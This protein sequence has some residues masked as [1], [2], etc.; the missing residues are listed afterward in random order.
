[1]DALYFASLEPQV[2][3]RWRFRGRTPAPNEFRD[4][5]FDPGVL[6][7]FMVVQADT[8]DPIGL[9]SSYQAS[10]VAKHCFVAF[11]RLRTND[12]GPTG[13]LMIEGL[14]IF[15][16]YLFDHFD[17]HKVYFEVPEYNASLFARGPGAIVEEEGRFK[18]HL[19]YGDRTWDMLTFALYRARW[20]SVADGFRGLWPD[21]HFQRR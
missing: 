14:L 8:D 4:N 16:Q 17:F 10:M 12:D 11:Q 15:V 5:L 20:E 9:V 21:D 6:A 18:D 19:Y 3:H 13:G 1:V 2:A 7:Q